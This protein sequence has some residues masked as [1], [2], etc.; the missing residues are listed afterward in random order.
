M[1]TLKDIAE[2]S[3]VS[4]SAVSRI[5]NNDKTLNVTKE[6]RQKVLAIAKEL[7][8]VKK[9]KTKASARKKKPSL[10]IGLFQWYSMFQELEDPY[11]QSIRNGIEACCLELN[12]RVVRIF[13]TD[14][15]Y[16]SQLSKVDGLICVGK[17]SKEDLSYFKSHTKHLIVVDMQTPSI[18]FSSI[19]LDFHQAV[20]D[21]MDYITGLG[22]KKIA[23]LG[24]IETVGGEIYFEQR[25][26][27]FIEYC[28]LHEIEYKPYLY[29]ETFSAESG[30]EMMKRL[31]EQKEVPTAVFA[32][33]DPIAIGALRAL[34]EAKLRVPEDISIIGFDDIPVASYTNPP[35]TTVFAP[36][37]FMGKKATKLLYQ[38]ILLD[39]EGEELPILVTLPC[40]LVRRDSCGPVPKHR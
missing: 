17:Y 18:S 2:K 1:A 33:S 37:E 5:L 25:K 34:Q 26:A 40:K 19:V 7:G 27:A 23:Y 20:F 15:D 24:G 9:S 4:L 28:N 36:A 3:Q 35:L 8:Y 11:Y 12:I 6:T 39:P 29:E 13:K 38:D 21:L 10:T 14:A 30:F 32:A 16:E 31:L 22:H